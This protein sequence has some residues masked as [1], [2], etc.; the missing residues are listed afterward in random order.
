MNCWQ[1]LQIE[2]TNNKKDIKRA[3]SKLL[4]VTHPEDDPESFQIL[5]ESYKS[6]LSM[7]EFVDED[8]IESEM[9]ED[10]V[11]SANNSE[12]TNIDGSNFDEGISDG[13][14]WSPQEYEVDSQT[15]KGNTNEKESVQNTFMQSDSE[16][17]TEDGS[18]S[19]SEII[20][21]SSEDV[22]E[23]QETSIYEFIE[24]FLEEIDKLCRT[25]KKR[26]NLDLWRELFEDE[27]LDDIEA[28]EILRFR[29]FHYFSNILDSEFK[30]YSNPPI[31]PNIVKRVSEFFGWR[32]DEISLTY[33]YQTHQIDNVM[34][35]A[36]GLAASPKTEV[37]EERKS[38]GSGGYW[39]FWIIAVF[40]LPKVFSA[41][42]KDTER[43]KEEPYYKRAPLKEKSFSSL[44]NFENCQ[45]I[46]SEYHE[47][48]AVLRC[49]QSATSGNV[50]ALEILGIKNLFSI[51]SDNS[52]QAGIDYLTSAA[53]KGS[54][55]AEL[56]LGFEYQYSL[57]TD[58]DIEKAKYWL[59][60]AL[61]QGHKN[62]PMM[63]ASAILLND[64]MTAD[65][66]EQL[67][68]KE[69]EERDQRAFNLLAMANLF[70]I[71]MNENLPESL[72]W[73][74]ELATAGDIEQVNEVAWFL[75]TSDIPQ[76]NGSNAAMN[77]ADYF[78]IPE[79]TT[80]PRYVDTLAAIYAASG[81]F[82]KAYV[83]QLNA[84]IHLKQSASEDLTNAALDEEITDYES[85][86]KL[87]LKQERYLQKFN[88]G[89][90]R[91]MFERLQ[92]AL[93]REEIVKLVGEKNA[94]GLNLNIN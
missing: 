4:K 6:A 26:N 43:P 32:E 56:I 61:S 80:N 12:F 86:S 14:E 17:W 34:T 28:K 38:S 22:A 44:S 75:A 33:H 81:D 59:S 84:I 20:V 10:E 73:F 74:E 77:Y 23:N 72:K 18:W 13:F 24:Y 31:K 65:E 82:A 58:K 27:R 83:T 37:I 7:A 55:V 16:G 21:Q 91:K 76:L 63:L 57:S 47:L 89:D 69:I 51:A 93:V 41:L 94:K 29:V 9:V 35:Y 71:G 79:P 88:E 85:R 52:H 30:N 5:S 64:K 15:N 48:S 68:S 36:Y 49:I 78:L 46:L 70:G 90:A 92:Y 19:N 50:K 45:L 3:Y 1:V 11:G 53:E 60:K 67:L 40:V 8:S 54:V 42:F 2:P 25:K 66:V 62:A 87:Y 39:L